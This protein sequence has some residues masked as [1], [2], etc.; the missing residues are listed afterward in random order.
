MNIFYKYTGMQQAGGPE[1]AAHSV[2]NG[3]ILP[4]N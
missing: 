2:Q 3:K 4:R 1:A